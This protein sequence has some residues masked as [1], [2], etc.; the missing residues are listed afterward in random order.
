MVIIFTISR[1]SVYYMYRQQVQWL[2]YVP[3]VGAVVTIYIAHLR[4]VSQLKI[5]DFSRE[6][7]K[8][9]KCYNFL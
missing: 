3:L 1:R 7:L 2:L 5:C 8:V 6:V 9:L 4:Q